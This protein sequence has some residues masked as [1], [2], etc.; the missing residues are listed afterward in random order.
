MR[1]TG[2]LFMGNTKPEVGRDDSGQFRL[3]LRL[4]DNMG[5]DGMEAYQVRWLGP[6]AE[7]FWNDQRANLVP[8]AIVDVELS[9]L[10]AHVGATRP[11]IPELRGRVVRAQV[12]PKRT[13]HPAAA[14]A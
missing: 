9:H 12:I 5:R 13:H 6:E 11:P 14:A 8:G 3:V 1:T 7:A 2:T 10:R 4:I